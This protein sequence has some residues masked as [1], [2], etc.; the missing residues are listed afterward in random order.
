[1]LPNGAPCACQIAD[2]IAFA[3]RF[4]PNSVFRAG[5]K[6]KRLRASSSHCPFCDDVHTH[7]A[8]E[9]NIKTLQGEKVRTALTKRTSS[10]RSVSRAIGRSS[11][12]VLLAKGY[13]NNDADYTEDKND[14]QN[15]CCSSPG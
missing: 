8:S 1:L 6:E 5:V 13:P 11:I 4:A 12:M 10:P 14:A 7:V 3:V 9:H 2:E 15:H